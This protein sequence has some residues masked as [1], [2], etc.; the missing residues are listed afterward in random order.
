MTPTQAY[1]QQLEEKLIR[2]DARQQQVITILETIYQ[3]FITRYHQRS[4]PLGKLRRSIKPRTP[5]QGLYLWGQVG[6]GKTF[7]IDLF[8]NCLP[9]KKMRIHF[10]QF[11]QN[12]HAELKEQQGHQDPLQ[13][14]AKKI[15]DDY[16]VICFDE[17]FVS[18]ITDAMLLGELFNHLFEGGLC[19][20]TTSNI[21]PD[22]LYKDGI[23]RENFLPTIELIKKYTKVVNLDSVLD[24]RLEHIHKGGI[25]FTPLDE[26]SKN[27]LTV[28]FKHFSDNAAFSYDGVQILGRHI[29]TKRHTEHVIWFDFIEICS[30]PRSQND[31][32]ELGKKYHTI[33]VSN[34]PFIEATET[35]SII[36]FI[37]LVDILYDQ[38]IRF[39]AQSAVPITEIYT[40][41]KKLFE[42]ERTKSRLIEMNSEDYLNNCRFGEAF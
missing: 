38:H 35:N 6:I 31:Y 20:I 40:D 41:G 21:A 29:Q 23:Q 37:E 14:I 22:D 17:F 7:L 36:L 9:A 12:L 28:C 11:M 13:R 18:N 25:Y 30:S 39:V 16:I 10:H 19:L 5:I 32:L 2:P 33:I 26:A 34:I 8:F 27:H 3:H 24:Y 42:F 15:A 1:Q 4:S